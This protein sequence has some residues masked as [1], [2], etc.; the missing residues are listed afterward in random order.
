MMNNN[1]VKNDLVSRNEKPKFSM[2]ITSDSYRKMLNNALQDPKRV[3][4]FLANTISVVSTNPKL[5]ECT[6]QTIVSAALIAESLNL[7]IQ[8]QLGYAYLVPYKNTKLGIDEAQFQLGWKGLVQLAIR[9][10][11]YK[12][13]NVIELKD[14]EVES[15]NLLNG[16]LKC[17]I[18][19]DFKKRAEA[20]TVGYYAMFELITG[21]TKS[22]YM[23]IEEMET[24]ANTYSKAFKMSEYQKLKSGKVAESDMWKYS[25]FW[26]KDFDAMAKKTMIR[27][28]LSQWG[29]LSAEL[30]EAIIKDEA[31]IRDDGKYEY[32][33]NDNSVFV[34]VKDDSF[35]NIETGEVEEDIT[36][37][38]K[39]ARSANKG[40]GLF[41]KED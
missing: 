17:V 39:E 12:N 13:I 38:F 33:D 25:S 9:T 40:T 37:K 41:G 6:P 2:V 4:R 34:D 19:T 5:S 36:K 27:R 10:G 28:L 23:P 14:G 32:V 21:F 15:Y 7:P 8:S 24:H 1:S 26:Y 11:Q 22:I 31:V 16:E 35:V 3:N 29:I 18:I 30:Q 20:K